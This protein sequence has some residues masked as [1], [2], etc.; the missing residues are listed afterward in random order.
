MDILF[1]GHTT[2]KY[3]ITFNNLGVMRKYRQYLLFK[4]IYLVSLRL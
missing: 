4:N 2:L 3:K 1:S